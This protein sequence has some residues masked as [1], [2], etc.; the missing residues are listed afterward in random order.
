MKPEPISESHSG[1]SSDGSVSP[2]SSIGCLAHRADHQH[3]V[4]RDVD[5]G[6][7]QLLLGAEVVVH[8]R[9]VDA[10]GG[11]DR[12]GSRSCRSRCARTVPARW[13][14][15]VRGCRSAR[16]VARDACARRRW[17]T[18]HG[19]RRRRVAAARHSATTANPT[20]TAMS[21]AAVAVRSGCAP[22]CCS[23]SSA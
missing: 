18:C 17:S 21:R 6:G 15:S 8:Q 2:S 14:G 5:R 7:E 3:R 11:G 16:A 13:P 23:A 1:S 10:G 19:V 4:D 12:R 22:T 20:T 9:G